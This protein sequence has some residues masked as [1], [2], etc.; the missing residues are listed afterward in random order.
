MTIPQPPSPLVDTTWLEAHLDDRDLL[1]I[2]ASADLSPNTPGGYVS[3]RDQYLAGHLPGAVF[4]DVVDALSEPDAALP[5]TRPSS[6]QLAA[7]FGGLGIGEE[8]MVVLYDSTTGSWAARVWWLLRS[9]G[10][11]R[12]VVLDGG[13]RLWTAQGRALETGQV[14]SSPAGFVARERP[15]LW[16]D[17]DSVLA[18]VRGHEHEHEHDTLLNAISRK[19]AGIPTEF[20]TP[21]THQIPGSTAVPYPDLIDDETGTLL[22]ED[23]LR[24]ALEDVPDSERTIVY[25]GSAIGAA[26]AALALVSLGRNDV[27]IY[28]GSLAEWL[29]DPDA[30]LEAKDM[31]APRGSSDA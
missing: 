25:C 12:A 15:E 21:F 19:P 29:A 9:L 10:H 5:L 22:P 31:A 23:D 28:D 7:A 11:D 30:P 14:S 3:L 26:T 8:T 16:A 13:L 6:E 18:V 20:A 2:D 27:A 1:V 17:K 24:G 4:A